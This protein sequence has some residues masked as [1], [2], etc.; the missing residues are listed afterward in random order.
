MKGEKR[1]FENVR[2][3]MARN[4]YTNKDVALALGI[5]EWAFGQKL[6]GY[7][8]FKLDEMAKI[9]QLLKNNLSIEYLFFADSVRGGANAATN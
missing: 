4:G 3:E 2:A 6:N 9:R 5:S 7:S 8:Q 1:M